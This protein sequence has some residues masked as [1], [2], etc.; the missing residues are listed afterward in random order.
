MIQTFQD[1]SEAGH[2]A[3]TYDSINI[4]KNVRSIIALTTVTGLLLPIPKVILHTF[5]VRYRGTALIY[6]QKVT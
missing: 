1:S 2:S 6:G 3:C 4:Y 5:K